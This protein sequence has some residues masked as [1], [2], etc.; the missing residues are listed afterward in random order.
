M[1]Y[2]ERVIDGILQSRGTPD[3]E[4]Q[5]VSQRQLTMLLLAA[6]GRVKELEKEAA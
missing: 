2:E 4:F 1:Y 3:G 6:R 5:P